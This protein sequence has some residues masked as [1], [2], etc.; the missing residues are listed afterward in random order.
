MPP[1]DPTPAHPLFRSV[2][3]RSATLWNAVFLYAELASMLIRNL[4]LVP[5]YL[6]HIS[7]AEYGAWLATAS[8]LTYLSSMDLGLTSVLPQQL[9]AA[10]GARDLERLSSVMATGLVVCLGIAVGMLALG[11][12]LSPLL[13]RTLHLDPD[14]RERLVGSLLLGAVSLGLN[15]LGQSLAAILRAFQRPVLP[16]LAG[17]AA[18]VVSIALTLVL[19]QRGFGLYALASCLVARGATLLLVNGAALVAVMGGSRGLS[20]RW[21]KEAARTLWSLSFVQFAAR[22]TS[23]L[24]A[25]ADPYL[26]GLLLGAESTAA[27]VLTVRAVDMARLLTIRVSEA[28]MPS[29]A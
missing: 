17:I 27:Y 24:S 10:Y 6:H 5:I 19:L 8:L 11:A 14:V 23:Q 9:A 26:I 20:F 3:R 7:L 13:P 21:S 4:A 28:V 15:L 2:S 22:I 25:M 29:L 1:S 18:D 12:G 16:G